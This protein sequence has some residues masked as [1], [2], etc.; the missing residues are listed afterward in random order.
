MATISSYERFIEALQHVGLDI[1]NLNHDQ[2]FTRTQVV[3]ET[4]DFAL[5]L[6]KQIQLNNPGSQALLSLARE[7]ENGAL[8][9]RAKKTLDVKYFGTAT[10]MLN[11]IATCLRQEYDGKS[12]E[13]ARTLTAFAGTLQDVASIDEQDRLV[14]GTPQTTRGNAAVASLQPFYQA[15]ATHARMA[16]LALAL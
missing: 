14:A 1:G 5:E 2:S 7:V 9:E 10:Q 8:I 11:A 12:D 16:A 15:L 3:S 4:I 6:G 13:A